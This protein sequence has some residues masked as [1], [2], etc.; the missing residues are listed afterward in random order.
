MNFDLPEEHN[1]VA[2]L[3]TRILEDHVNIEN[4]R[5]IEA[6]GDWFDRALW[7][8]FVSSGIIGVTLSEDV[9]GSGLDILALVCILRSQG[10]YVAPIPLLPN[11]VSAMTIDKFGSK[12][13]RES[14]LPEV[15]DDSKLLTFA[16]QEFLNDKFMEPH[17]EFK[18][19]VIT[20]KK[21]VVEYANHSDSALVTVTTDEGPAVCIVDLK[22]PSIAM[23]SSDS[24]RGEPLWEISFTETPAEKLAGI[25][26]VLWLFQVSLVGLCATQLGVTETAL[27]MTA[28]YTSEREQFGRPLATFQAVTQRL[29]DQ[30]INV[31]GIRL[32]TFS[33][34]WRLSA[35][36]DALEDTLIA[37]W[38][39]SE[40]ATEIAHAS[41][42]C[43]G[44]MGVSKDYPL[45][46]YTLWNKHIT[47]SL[48]AGTQTLRSLGVLLASEQ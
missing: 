32:T 46:R 47:T 7:E 15:I 4:L 2:E 35:D 28:S 39:A 30:F 23:S 40:R 41:Q 44:G 33:A 26:S 36:L 9:G 29:A 10:Q 37:K 38:W 31:G 16:S 8:K 20:G 12:E 25:E 19:G 17:T 14:L 22:D 45:H 27:K 6:A 21:L 1:E 43:H 18:D 11:L 5:E 42:H 48:G 3:T 24:T 13:L 34:A